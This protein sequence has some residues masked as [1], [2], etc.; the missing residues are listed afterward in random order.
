MELQVIIPFR[1]GQICKLL[2]PIADENPLD[3]YIVSE[4]PELLE[5]DET[6]YITNL[7]DLQRNITNPLA[8]PQIAVTKNEL[9]VVA[10]SLETYISSWNHPA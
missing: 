7:R 5:A 10:D 8:A 9:T 6:I 1:A 3:V 4:D 2:N